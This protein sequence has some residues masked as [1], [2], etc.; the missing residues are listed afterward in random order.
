[1]IQ[2]SA[3]G[4]AKLEHDPQAEQL[5]DHPQRPVLDQVSG[6]P[7]AVRRADGFEQPADVGVPQA[8]DSAP[9]S[10]AAQVRGVRVA[11]LV[12][13]RVVLAVVGDPGDHRT[14]DGHRAEHRDHGLECPRGFERAVGEHPV[15]AE[16]H[17]EA[18]DHVRADQQGQ[19]ERADRLVPEQHDRDDQPDQWERHA[20]QVDDLVRQRHHG[21]PSRAF[22]E[23][24]SSACDLRAR[25]P[26][27][28]SGSGSSGTS[29]P[30]APAAISSCQTYRTGIW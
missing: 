7:L 28:G 13:E 22:G 20:D 30:S 5:V 17:A 9:E 25:A 4:I 1:M 27:S 8:L 21:R 14:L 24:V 19:L 10:G 11:L 29:G 3:N 2:P 16:R 12:G 18:G 26:G 23:R 15:V 6:E